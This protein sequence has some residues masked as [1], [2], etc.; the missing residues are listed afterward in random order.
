MTI[1][2]FAPQYHF[3]SNA[4]PAPVWL[5]QVLYAHV[6]VAYQAAKSDD[7]DTRAW[8]RDAPTVRQVWWRGRTVKLPDDW[9]ERRVAIMQKLLH[10]KFTQ[11]PALQA[12]LLATGEAV[13]VYESRRACD[14]FWGTCEGRGENILGVLLMELRT[15]LQ[16]EAAFAAWKVEMDGVPPEKPVRQRKE[17]DPLAS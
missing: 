6:D 1:L 17:R 10:Q 12:R 5:D 15:T 4:A 2:T 11:H 16:R 3:L 7:P 14:T 13:L 9:D 8:I